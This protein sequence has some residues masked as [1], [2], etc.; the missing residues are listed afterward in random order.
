MRKLQDKIIRSQRGFTLLEI[1]VS[2]LI[3]GI[4]M[5]PVGSILYLF[6]F[7]PAQLTAA[8]TV[9]NNSR[10]AVRQIAEDARQATSFSTSTDPEYGTF[11]WTDRTR[12][13]VSTHSVRYLFSDPESSLLREE[14]VGSSTLVS[15]V[16]SNIQD[17]EDVSIVLAG[18]VVIASVTSTTDIIFA[19]RTSNTSIRAQM[20][21]DL[22]EAQPSPPPIRLAWDDYESDDFSGGTGWS[23]DWFVSGGVVVSS[24]N[25]P[26]EGNFHVELTGQGATSSLERSLDLSGETSVSITFAV[27]VDSF[28]AGDKARLRVSPDEI[29]FTTV[30]TWDDAD[31]DGVYHIEE[32]GLSLF[33]MSSE[34][35]ILFEANL[36]N[37]G[38]LFF[39]DDIEIVTAW[40]P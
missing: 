15:L 3:I 10:N 32:I 24:S 5:V 4:I 23:G 31:S 7:S 39:I 28:E 16:S 6:I 2:L 12:F 27:K 35:I 34:F 25:G 29:E 19:D 36:S 22:P 1:I 40:E 8:V 14:T 30:R 38:D 17:Y 13:P 20:R 26:F 37:S 21:P 11:V 33:T 18:T 9:A